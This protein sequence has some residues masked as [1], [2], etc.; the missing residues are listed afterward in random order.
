MLLIM[1]IADGVLF[2]ISY[3]KRLLKLCILDGDNEI[4][5]LWTEGSDEW[6]IVHKIICGEVS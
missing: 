6:P 3:L 2:G 1:A 4:D 5:L